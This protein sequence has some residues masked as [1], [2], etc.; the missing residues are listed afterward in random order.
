MNHTNNIIHSKGMSEWECGMCECVWVGRRDRDRETERKRRGDV[1]TDLKF[2]MWEKHLT[3]KPWANLKIVKR[4]ETENKM[5]ICRTV[6][7][8]K[9]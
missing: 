5:A 8:R 3:Q 1:E 7:K 4:K 9:K 6:L 2:Q